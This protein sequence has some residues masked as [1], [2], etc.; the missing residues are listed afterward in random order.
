MNVDFT[1]LDSVQAMESVLS[2]APRD[3]VVDVETVGSVPGLEGL[4]GVAIAFQ[5]NSEEAQAYYVL[6]QSWNAINQTL[7]RPKDHGTMAKYLTSMLRGKELIGHNIEY[8]RKWIDA[9]FGIRS[10]WKADTRIMWHLLDTE[11]TERGYGLKTAQTKI[12][13]WGASNEDEL[14]NAVEL[15]GGKLSKGDHYLAPVYIMAKY[16]KLDALATLGLFKLFSTELTRHDYWFFY[17]NIQRYGRL[18]AQCT[19][20]GVDVNKEQLEFS[21]QII[22]KRVESLKEDIHAIC[23][24]QIEHLEKNWYVDD[25]ASYKTSRGVANF[26]SDYHKHRRF[27]PSSSA[28]KATL[29]YELLEVPVTERTPTGRP[30]ADKA[31]IAAINHPSAKPFVEL[32]ENEKLLSMTESY[33]DCI[34][35]NRIHFG[36]NICGTV[37]GRLG[38]FKPYAL[39]LPFDSEEVM[40]PFTVSSGY[41]GIHSDL[42]SVEPCLI[43]AYSQDPT[44]LKVH[45]DGLGDVYLDFALIAFPDNRDLKEIYRPNEVCTEQVKNHFKKIRKA[46]KI[47]H[48]A[49]GY[50]GTAV[51]VARSLSKEGFPTTEAEARILVA[52]Y[53]DLFYRVKDLSARCRQVVDKNGFILNAFGRRLSVPRMFRKDSMNRLIQS[54]GHDALVA[55]VREIDKR[56]KK[57]LPSMRPVLIDTH[58]STTWECPEGEYEVANR[59]FTDSLRAIND[60]LGLPVTLSC[61]TKQFHTFYGLKNNED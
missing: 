12:L 8:D 4:L 19:A 2:K 36:Y 15:A 34:K 59:I 38:G 21:K 9:S 33:L 41:V 24:E 25:I 13:G 7:E 61:E 26:V 52:K 45:R 60:R 31:T 35:D 53:W 46:C 5:N 39:N 3:V 29:F 44:L 48:L 10:A 17:R 56:R 16:A 28:Q 11:Q 14:K 23:K 22:E 43:A 37:T 47:V 6:F 51:T 20:R 50:T 1:V 18:L 49:V 27:N 32:A 57:V 30:K 58:D 54:S 55:W 42:K 40:R